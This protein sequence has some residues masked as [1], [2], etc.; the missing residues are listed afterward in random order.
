MKPGMIKNFIST[1]DAAF[2]DKEKLEKIFIASGNGSIFKGLYNCKN[3]QDYENF[4]RHVGRYLSS[5][6]IP[7]SRPSDLMDLFE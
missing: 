1:V 6:R 2:L 4:K 7:A 5:N 3:T